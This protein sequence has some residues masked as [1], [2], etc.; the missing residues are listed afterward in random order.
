MILLANDWNLTFLIHNFWLKILFFYSSQIGT[1][2]GLGSFVNKQNLQWAMN[3]VW[4]LR[5]KRPSTNST[6]TTKVQTVFT[7]SP[8]SNSYPFELPERR[9]TL[10]ALIDEFRRGEHQLHRGPGGDATSWA[11]SAPVRGQLLKAPPPLHQPQQHTMKKSASVWYAT[12]PAPDRP[13]VT[14][15]SMPNLQSET[16]FDRRQQPQQSSGPIPEELWRIVC[17]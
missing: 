1:T 12:P 7:S 5:E 2:A 15:M 13:L 6:P 17:I 4:A 8:S 16:T 11:A 9:S 10:R 3:E 14:R